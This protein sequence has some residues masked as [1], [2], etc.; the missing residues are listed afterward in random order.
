M[1]DGP[2]QGDVDPPLGNP[3][4]AKDAWE[5][6]LDDMDRTAEELENEG[7]DVLAVPAGSTAAEPPEDG[8]KGRFGFVH[9]VP[10]NFADEFREF[11]AAGEFPR[12]DVYRKE[13]EG[14]VYFVTALFAPEVNKAILIAG[15][16]ELRAAGPLYETAMGENEIY[17]HV[18]KLDQTT[19]GSFRHDAIEKFFPDDLPFETSTDSE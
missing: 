19:L 10:G 15:T 1:T 9:V 13:V 14:H 11:V 8:P 4:I 17:T 6:T 16:Y 5:R 12:F 3:A 18:Q 7:W 2:R